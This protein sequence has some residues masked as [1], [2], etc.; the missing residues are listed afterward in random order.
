ML[1][2]TAGCVKR[3]TTS[4]EA[5]NFGYAYNNYTTKEANDK[6]CMSKL[7]YSQAMHELCMIS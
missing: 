3:D 7:P 6:W 4:Q 2:R 5:Y 1:Y